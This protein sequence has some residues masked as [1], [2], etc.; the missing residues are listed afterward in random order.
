M[1]DYPVRDGNDAIILANATDPAWTPPVAYDPTGDY[2]VLDGLGG[3]IIAEP[4]E[5]GGGEPPVITLPVLNVPASIT[6]SPV[7][8]GNAVT[9]TP[10]TYT[11]SAITSFAGVLTDN[12]VEVQTRSVR[13]PFSY[14]P[15]VTGVDRNLVWSEV[16]TNSAGSSGPNTA[17]ATVEAEEVVPADQISDYYGI[18]A[19]DIPMD[20]LFQNAIVDG[21]NNVTASPNA[22]GAGTAFD[23]TNP[24][25]VPIP[26]VAGR[27]ELTPSMYMRFTNLVQATGP[28]LMNTRV[29]MDVELG[30]LG[31][32]QFLLGNGSP[33]SNISILAGGGTLRLTRRNPSTN[34]VETVNVPISPVL[35]GGRRRYEVEFDLAAALIR[36]YV[37]GELR[38]QAAHPYPEYRV[39]N[40]AAGQ[41]PANGNGMSAKIGRVLSMILGGAFATRL[42]IVQAEFDDVQGISI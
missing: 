31:V 38:G 7:V 18:T 41:N 29:M 17:T 32:E 36:F 42:P 24:G 35:S 14:T 9:I 16:A 21:S 20:H 3:V 8:E 39:W 25:A 10:A 34:T 2:P 1:P 5:G 22:G 33:Q 28:D 40:F 4:F 23:L 15:A 30:S 6:P 37:N 19:G 27:L 26:R 13:T 11:G 12:G